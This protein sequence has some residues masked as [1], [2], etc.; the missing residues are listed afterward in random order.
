LL[1]Y[2]TIDEN[3]DDSTV[4]DSVIVAADLG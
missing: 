2:G 4:Y 1:A 3:G